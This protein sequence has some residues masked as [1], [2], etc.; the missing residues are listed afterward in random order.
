MLLAE[1]GEEALKLFD[2]QLGKQHPFAA[3]ILDIV[4]PVMGGVETAH[5]L[6]NRQS[7]FPI[8]LTT[9]YAENVLP[10]ELPDRQPLQLLIK[11]FAIQSLSKALESIL[12]EQPPASRSNGN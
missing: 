5:Q 10:A 2:R 8:L 6:R 9:G 4:M 7:D 1:N 12:C 3:A 11:P